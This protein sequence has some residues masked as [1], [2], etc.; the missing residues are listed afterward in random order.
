MN[1]KETIRKK[2]KLLSIA[3]LASILLRCIANAPFVGIGAVI[4]MGIGAVVIGLVL[5]FLSSKVPPIPM[6]FAF[7]IFMSVL[8]FLLM[9]FWPCKVNFMMTYMALFFAIM[10]EDIRVITLQTV[11]CAAEMIYFH[12][13]Y[14][15]WLDMEW[16]TDTTVIGVVYLISGMIVFVMLSR[17]TKQQFAELEKTNKEAQEEKEKAEKLLAQIGKS[18]G[19]LDNTSGKI[20][21]SVNVSG[22]I[23]SEIAKATEEVAQ[24]AGDEV[25]AADTIR[26]MVSDGVEN[27]QQVAEASVQMSEASNETNTA[28][29]QSDNKVKILST[30]M[31]NLNQKMDEIATAIAELSD[32]N[33][34]IVGILGTLGEI[35]DQTNLLSLNASIEAARAGEAGKGFAV[36]AD[37]IRNLS[38]SSAQFT[39]E[40]HGI[41]D[42]VEAKTRQV[43]EEIAQGQ[44]SVQECDDYVKEV[45]ESFTIVRSNSD[46]ILEKAQDIESKSNA[47]HSLLNNTLDNVNEISSNVESTSAAMEEIAASINNLND[48]IA[49][50]VT[51]YN[52]IN[53]ITAS[54]VEVSEQ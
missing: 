30:R 48:S 41:L 43:T 7:S 36:V 6:M 19:V 45:G 29:T 37:E 18:V 34:K 23:T 4:P 12:F 35:S 33:N 54:L 27:I 3:L 52:D 50:V 26:I 47:L 49:D 44:V 28:I 32:E 31:D 40:I 42:G 16:G 8:V 13:K 5:F 46:E 51:G 22:D 53:D 17:M 1:Y 11:C 21:T 38:D 9:T 24:R 25:E 20:S 39:D 2:N 10:Y 14:Y 15:D